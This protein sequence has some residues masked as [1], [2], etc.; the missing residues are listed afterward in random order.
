MIEHLPPHNTEAEEAVLGSLLMDNSAIPTVA[1]ILKAEDFFRSQN[2]ELYQA[3]LALFKSGRPLDFLTLTDELKRAG[4][5]KEIGGVEYLQRLVGVV[6]T[7]V[8]VEHYAGIVVRC[9][10]MRRLISASA[11]IAQKAYDETTE[12]T[13]ALS[14]AAEQVNAVAAGVDNGEMHDSGQRVAI[15]MDYISALADPSSRQRGLATGFDV[16]FLIGGLRPGTL[17]MVGGFTG[18]GK[19]AWMQTTA[20]RQVKRGYRVMFAS[21]EMTDL[22][23]IKRDIASLAGRDWLD[24]ETDLTYPDT[25]AYAWASQQVGEAIKALGEWGLHVFTKGGM[26]TGDIRRE[27]ARLQM[28]VG[29]VDAVYVDYLQRLSDPPA[30]RNSQRY[31]DVAAMAR[32]LKNMAI[33]LHV[34]VVCAAQLSRSVEARPKHVPQLSDFRESGD[35]ECESDVVI[36]LNRPAAWEDAPVGCSVTEARMYLLKNRGGLAPKTLRMKWLGSRVEYDND[37]IGP[38]VEPAGGE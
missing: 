3:A 19:S 22:E 30:K 6:P 9:A 5:L 16:D 20:R 17:T 11:K 33:D 25:A 18:M 12:P 34:P 37:S 32:A 10:T 35:I 1:S 23:L 31:Q 24:I 27:L 21:S 2:A 29:P 28:T 13:A 14:F 8:H 7:T 4:T 36:G 15:L 38:D 26:T